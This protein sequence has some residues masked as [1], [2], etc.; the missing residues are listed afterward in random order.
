[1]THKA[2]TAP[3]EITDMDTDEVSLVDRGANKKK[4][5]PFYK[6]AS[7]QGRSQMQEEILKAVLETPVDG[8]DRF[9]Q[10]I[11]KALSD[12]AVAALK[13]A[14]RLLVGFK[15]ELPQDA[16]EKL[17]AAAGYGYPTPGGEEAAAPDGYPA[18]E[19]KAT[20]PEEDKQAEGCQKA[21]MPPEVEAIFKAQAS[22]LEAVRKQLAD[23]TDRRRMAEWIQKARTDLSHYP[24]KSTDD[25]AKMLFDMEK[26]SPE[27]AGASFD[28]MKAVSAAFSGSPILKSEGTSAAPET[29]TGSVVEQIRKEADALIAKAEKP[30]TREQ[31]VAKI[32]RQKPEMY[33]AYLKER[34]TK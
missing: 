17:A 9:V 30:M 21:A 18:P 13:G 22:E 1:M 11:Q 25:L 32:V 5:F 34:E 8:E 29:D 19:E 24:G 27:M 10:G 4:R 16:L 23:E 28:S 12:Q 3:Q 15:D 33:A 2:E 20:K 26:L 6:A 7:K 14:L 31:A